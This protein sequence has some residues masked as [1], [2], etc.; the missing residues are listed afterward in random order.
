MLNAK[1]IFLIIKADAK[2][3]FDLHAQIVSIISSACQT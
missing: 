3:Y 1:I 2:V